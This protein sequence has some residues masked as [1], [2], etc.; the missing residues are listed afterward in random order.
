L[1]L[2]RLF[3][4]IVDALKLAL[5]RE[6]AAKLKSFSHSANFFKKY[7]RIV[8][9]NGS[10]RDVRHHTKRR[11]D[12]L[13]GAALLSGCVTVCRFCPAPISSLPFPSFGLVAVAGL[14]YSRG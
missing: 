14:L 10:E 5:Q 7:F 9:K 2:W 6:S 12:T 3:V 8:A 11:V 1:L 4:S 13:V